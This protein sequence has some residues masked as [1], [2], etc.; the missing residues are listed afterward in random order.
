LAVFKFTWGSTEALLLQLLP[1]QINGLIQLIIFELFWRT[2][3]S[4]HLRIA[5]LFRAGNCTD[6]L[7]QRNADGSDMYVP[8]Y[9]NNLAVRFNVPLMQ[10]LYNPIPEP[11]NKMVGENINITA[12]VSAASNMRLLLNGNVIQTAN[13]VT[14]ISANPTLTVAGNQTLVAEAVVGAV[15]KTET[16]NFF[17]AN[18]PTVAALPAGVRDGINYEQ[19]TLLLFWFYMHRVKTVCQ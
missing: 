17:V 14:S 10:P 9:D 15:T 2:S 7:A 16:I 3:E 13:N 18:A 8:V 1:E 6:C 19:E 12:V 4:N 5:I 11:I